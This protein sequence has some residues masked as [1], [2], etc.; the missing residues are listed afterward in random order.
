MLTPGGDVIIHLLELGMKF[1]PEDPSLIKFLHIACFQGNSTYVQK[2]PS[3][4]VDIHTPAG[5]SSDQD[6][7]LGTA[8]HAAA[9][10]GQAEIIRILLDSCADPSRRLTVHVSRLLCQDRLE[11]QTA[12]QVATYAIGAVHLV[13]LK[14]DI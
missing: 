6:L 9:Y 3:R 7:R 1:E 5:Y 14:S 2:T 4:N 12:I 10:G 13:L 11:N 8:L